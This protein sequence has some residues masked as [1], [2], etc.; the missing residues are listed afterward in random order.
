MADFLNALSVVG[1]ILFLCQA[2]SWSIDPRGDLGDV[3]LEI[4]LLPSISP[5]SIACLPA[6]SIHYSSPFQLL[7]C[8]EVHISCG[9]LYL[10]LYVYL[11]DYLP[12]MLNLQEPLMLLIP[13]VAWV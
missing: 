5:S 3:M 7:L 10:V 12:R 4:Y 11:G 6:A 8:S 2:C 9:I 1:I 13:Q